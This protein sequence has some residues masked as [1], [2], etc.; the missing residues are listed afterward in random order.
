MAELKGIK[1]YEPEDEEEEG[2]GLPGGP[3]AETGFPFSVKRKRRRTLRDAGSSF[4]TAQ[5]VFILF[6]FVL[7]LVVGGF[8]MHQYV[9]PE[10]N[11]RLV[12]DFNALSAANTALDHK[13]DV[14]VGC[15][16]SHQVNPDT[17]LRQD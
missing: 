1:P 8:L 7:G 9:E 17:C 14:L 6:I 5:R 16:Q 11:K 3:E 13:V 2:E 4:W 12:N 15:L 10:L